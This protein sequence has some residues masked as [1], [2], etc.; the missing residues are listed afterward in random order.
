[1]FTISKSGIN[2]YFISFFAIGTLV[3]GV[4]Y[5]ED[6][7]T[8]FG[9]PWTWFFIWFGLC[10]ILFFK[11]YDSKRL[12]L[13]AG[14]FIFIIFVIIYNYVGL[15]LGHITYINFNHY[16]EHFSTLFITSSI[17]FLLLSHFDKQIIPVVLDKFALMMCFGLLV[18]RLLEFDFSREGFFLGLGPLTFIKYVS[19]GFLSRL[20]FLKRWSASTIFLY[21]FAFI[22]AASKGPL[23]FLAV[24]VLFK[25]IMENELNFKT[26]ILF[27]LFSSMIFFSS[28]RINTFVNEVQNLLISD[29]ITVVSN[30]DVFFENVSSTLIRI[31]SI[32]KT[33]E[34]IQD[35]YIFGVGAGQ[36]P[37]EAGLPSVSYPHN[38]ILEIWSEYG[39]LPLMIFIFILLRLLKECLNSNL[40][41]YLA[42][43]AFLTTMTSGTI[44]DLRFFA[45][46]AML[47]FYLNSMHIY[48]K[49]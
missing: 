11:I 10:L 23:L 42:L 49:K 46:Y 21:M 5:P 31:Y 6:K 16:L 48:E 20:F 13:I 41:G 4:I 1:M 27:S 44:A 40:Y 9:I 22:V 7:N 15:F 36:W 29:E 28:D 33:I 35:N 32:N 24:I 30:E 39:L 19:I 12:G 34:L 18:T 17:V 38:S 45:V 14:F 3:L 26:I 8:L 43:F 2:T 25:L 37:K 47:T